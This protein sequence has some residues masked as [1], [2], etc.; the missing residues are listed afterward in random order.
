VVA[1]PAGT[2]AMERLRWPMKPLEDRMKIYRP[3]E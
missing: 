1:A 3:P 2:G